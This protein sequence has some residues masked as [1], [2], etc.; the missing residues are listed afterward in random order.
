[1]NPFLPL[2]PGSVVRVVAPSGVVPVEPLEA[3]LRV[4]RDW[5]LVVRCSPRVRDRHRYLA[6]S[7]RE[8]A[9]EW[10]EAFREPEVEGVLAARGGYGAMRILEAVDDGVPPLPRVFLGF[11]DL[12]ALHVLRFRQGAT[13]LHGANVTTLGGLDAQSLERTR[14]ALF[15][16][17]WRRTFRWEGLRGLRG[18]RSEGRLVAGN[19]S[20]LC[21][22]MGTRYEATMEGCIWVVEDVHEPPY[23]L[24]RL[25]TQVGL[26]RQAGG[27]RGL[28][29]GDLGV[30]RD[31]QE[32]REAVKEA[33]ECLAERLSCPVLA[34]FPAGHRGPLHPVPVGALAGLDGD[35][36]VLQVLED[37]CLRG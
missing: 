7:D 24:D 9:R 32:A 25:L 20:M 37:P 22:L 15:G 23:R 3:G 33:L 31:D 1:M 26:A 14:R 16:E 4:L 8:R 28:V 29:V 17:D 12:T 5:G 35:D 19:L 13:G 27:L 11:S 34:G 18:G 30:D 6:G 10:Q 21:A 2:R 36:G